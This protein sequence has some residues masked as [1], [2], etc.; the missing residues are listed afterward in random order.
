MS[1]STILAEK[2]FVPAPSGGLETAWASIVAQYPPQAIEFFGTLLVQLIAYWVPVTI[3]Q[4][5]DILAPNFSHKHKIQPIPKQPTSAEIGRAFKITARNQIL[6]MFLHA[7]LLTSIKY[8]HNWDSSYRVIPTLPSWKEIAWQLPVCILIREIMFY[9]SHKLLHHPRFYTRIHKF[10]HTFTAPVACAAQYAHPI[11]HI[12]ANVLPVS[13]PPQMVNAHILTN[14][15][16]LGFVLFE[17]VTVHSGYD[18]AGGVAAMHDLHH[19]RFV[20]NYGTV[21]IWDRVLGTYRRRKDKVEHGHEVQGHKV[22]VLAGQTVVGM[23]EA[24]AEAKKMR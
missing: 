9:H 15:L 10:H 1:N 18:F 2:A 21:G 14:W 12:F 24:S 6:N 22:E 3:Y 20:G 17:T 13:S 5:L 19:E 7:F 4:T 16:F 23:D 11:E 8:N